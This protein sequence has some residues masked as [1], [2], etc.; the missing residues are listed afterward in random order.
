M[1]W[2]GY[3][4]DWLLPLAVI[5]GV[6]LACAKPSPPGDPDWTAEPLPL[7]PEAMSRCDRL[8]FETWAEDPE[9]TKTDALWLWRGCREADAL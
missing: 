4:I 2:L 3:H 7:S 1:R 9:L 5:A 8:Y 6:F